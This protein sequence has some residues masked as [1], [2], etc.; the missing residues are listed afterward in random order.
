MNFVIVAVRKR[1]DGSD[2]CQFGNRGIVVEE[3]NAR[4]LG[5]ALGYQAG[6]VSANGTIRI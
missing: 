3:V 4:D 6:S 2:G 1:K 5:E